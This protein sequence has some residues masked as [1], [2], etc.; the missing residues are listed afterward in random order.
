MNGRRPLLVV[1]GCTASGKTSALLRL[2]RTAPLEVV[3]ADSRQ[4]YRGMDT[5]TAKPSREE[6]EAVP[7][8]LVDILDPDQG[9]S[10]GSFARDALRIVR[11]ISERG[12]IPV[13][14][15]GTVLY[16]MALTG[17]LDDLPVA[18]GP[19]RKTL[20]AMDASSPGFLHR[21]LQRL[22]P[23][24]AGRLS[25]ADSVR[26]VRAI[27]IILLSGR[28]ASALRTGGSNRGGFRIVSLETDRAELRRRIARRT[29]LMLSAGLVDETRSLLSRGY[30]R[31]SALGRTIGY[32]ECLDLLD[33]RTETGRLPGLIEAATWRYARRQRNMIG[34]LKPDAVLGG[35][36]P[37][38]LARFLG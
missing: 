5:G 8:H 35:D 6:M 21:M 22:D 20:L 24:T 19:L 29:S 36:D 31:A 18:H 27:E 2:A 37:E 28:R 17:G 11:E 12:R 3:S 32:S 26:T 10:A 9:Y 7:H 1:T 38:G 15:G 13:V 34:R 30:G 4:V 33:G 16:L 14:A 25:A 23:A